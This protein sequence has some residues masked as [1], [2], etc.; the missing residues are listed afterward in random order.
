[1]QVIAAVS[2]VRWVSVS[3]ASA[4]RRPRRRGVCRCPHSRRSSDAADDV[5]PRARPRR[6]GRRVRRAARRRWLPSVLGFGIVAVA[7]IGFSVPIW[8]GHTYVL[9]GI[10]AV[11]LL[12]CY[13]V[14]V[15]L[16]RCGRVLLAVGRPGLEA[17]YSTVWPVAN[18]LLTVPLALLAGML[19]VRLATASDRRCRVGVLGLALPADPAPT[20]VAPQAELVALRRRGRRPDAAR[21]ARRPAHGA[22]QGSWASSSREYRR[23]SPWGCWPE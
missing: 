20:A 18:G 12:S 1:M 16:H 22:S 9:S 14:H 11:I 6:D 8:L 10:T 21:R 7:A 23:S 19:G 2:G 5:V 15:R 17:R 13:I 3:T 4:C